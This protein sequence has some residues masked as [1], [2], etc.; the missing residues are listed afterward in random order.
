MTYYIVINYLLQCDNDH[1]DIDG[2]IYAGFIWR[3]F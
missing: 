3:N 1:N 2:C